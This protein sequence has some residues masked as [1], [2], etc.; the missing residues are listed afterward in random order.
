VDNLAPAYGLM[1][2]VFERT[3]RPDFKCLWCNRK[4]ERSQMPPKVQEE[5]GRRI[6]NGW[7]VWAAITVPL[8][9]LFVWVFILRR[10]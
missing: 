10:L 1:F 5:V 9:A 8:V 3:L 2:G 7:I 6:R 4:V